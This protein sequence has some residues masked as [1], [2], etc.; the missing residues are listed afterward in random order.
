MQPTLYPAE[1]RNTACQ[2]SPSIGMHAL[3]S[4]SG[5]C[6]MIAG[7][8]LAADVPADLPRFDPVATH[9]PSALP[10]SNG[11]GPA[12]K[13]CPEMVPDCPPPCLIFLSGEA[14][15][16]HSPNGCRSGEGSA[17][18]RH[19]ARESW[20]CQ[21]GCLPLFRECV[22]SRHASFLSVVCLCRRDV[23]EP[24]VTCRSR[25]RSHSRLHARCRGTIQGPFRP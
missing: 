1:A 10:A 7:V 4:K 5:L 12:C 8:G 23:A 20:I 15:S 6:V 2:P 24:A 25:I 13:W 3:R 19:Q 9:V 11:Q 16:V 18:V 17:S 22:G 21:A 14:C